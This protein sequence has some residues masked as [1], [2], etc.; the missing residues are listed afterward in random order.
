MKA[1]VDIVPSA[2]Q[3]PIISNPQN[4]V[5]LIRGAAGSGKT[6]TA[7]LMLKQLSAFW[8][9]HRERNNSFDPVQILVLSFNSTLR[10]YINHLAERQ[11]ESHTQAIIDIVTFGKWSKDMTDTLNVLNYNQR[12]TILNGFASSIN[13]PN[14]FLCDEIEYCLA[15]F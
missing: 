9:R 7:L 14:D 12:N 2:E 13:L 11:V 3:L 10:G 4:G 1:L 15:V 5:T 6:T 8:I